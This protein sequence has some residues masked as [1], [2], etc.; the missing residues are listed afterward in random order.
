M[1]ESKAGKEAMRRILDLDRCKRISTKGWAT[2]MPSPTISV[3]RVRLRR[4]SKVC[5]FSVSR[6]D[7]N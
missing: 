1:K 3:R 7:L 2:V 4:C 5:V 6:V